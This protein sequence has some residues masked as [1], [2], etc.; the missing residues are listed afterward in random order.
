MPSDQAWKG[1]AGTRRRGFRR[2]AGLELH[3]R[4]HILRRAHR[5]P[6]RLPAPRPRC[7][8]TAAHFDTE[9]AEA[10]ATKPAPRRAPPKAPERQPPDADAV[11]AALSRAPGLRNLESLGFGAVG[12]AG[13]QLAASPHL[14]RQGP[15]TAP[16]PG[17]GRGG[18]GDRRLALPR[19]PG[20]RPPR[21]R[22][23]RRPGAVGLARSTRLRLLRQ[24]TSAVAPGS[25]TRL[26]RTSLLDRL[27]ALT[28]TPPVGAGI[29]D[30]GAAAWRV[31]RTARLRF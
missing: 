24:L 25:S 21:L 3:L 16:Q 30:T 29:T 23:G 18:G 7:R 10:F 8:A 15:V 6:T 13:V 31:R 20:A 22:R 14:T 28:E 12:V 5:P 2:P 17:R 27:Q 1:V 19:G 26:R 9:G 4:G 11:A